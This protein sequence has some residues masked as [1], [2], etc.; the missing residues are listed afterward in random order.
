MDETLFADEERDWSGIISRDDRRWT[1]LNDSTGP[2][3]WGLVLSQTL[4][5]TADEFFALGA[6][7]QEL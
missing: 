7:S 5:F 2:S 3:L 1:F 4:T 6:E